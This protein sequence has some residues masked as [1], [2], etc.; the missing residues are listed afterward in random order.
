MDLATKLQRAQQSL[1]SITQHDDVPVAIRKIAVQR[2]VA[3][4]EA[5]VVKAEAR[6][7]AAE[8]AAVAALDAPAP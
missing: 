4:L 3:H 7:A 5:E 6:A 2:L 1:D 8:A